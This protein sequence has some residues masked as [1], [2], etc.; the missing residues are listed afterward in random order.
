MD[1]WSQGTQIMWRMGRPGDDWVQPMTVVRDD[2]RGLVAWLAMGTPV[3]TKVWPDGRDRRA[4]ARAVQAA[5]G[6]VRAVVDEALQAA[7]VR[8][9]GAWEGTHVLRVVPAGA[10]WSVW[11]F[12]DGVTGDFQGWY[13]NLELPHARE[14]F[15]TRSQDLTLDLWITPD[16]TVHRKDED[17]LALFVER[18]RITPDEAD[19]IRGVCAHVEQVVAAWGSPFCDGWETFRPDPAWPVPGLP[20]AEVEA[21]APVG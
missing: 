13:V 4:E 5:G 2:E 20:A 15:A 9:V 19:R 11:H 8:T 21:L 1:R 12:F 17:E 3:I 16:R 6:D 10:P 14:P 18:G 7:R